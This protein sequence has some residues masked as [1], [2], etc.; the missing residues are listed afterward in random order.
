MPR[1]AAGRLVDHPS[2]AGPRGPPRPL[3]GITGSAALKLHI[4]TD[5]AS[6]LI[7]G[8]AL[9]A[10]N[11]AD[12]EAAAPLIG[13]VQA[14]EGIEVATVLADMAYSDGDT[15]V[16]VE[17]TGAALVA[18]VPPV[19][20]KG[21]FA[22]TDFVIDTVTGVVTCPAGVAT[23][24]ARPAKDHKGRAALRFVFAAGAC[25][26]CALRA[27]CTT[28]A[29]SRSIVVGIHEDR[30]AAARAAQEDPAIKALLRRRAKVERKIAHLQHLGMGKARYRGRV[31]TMLQALLAAAVANFNR[32]DVLGVFDQV[33]ATVCGA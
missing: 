23:T 5:E 4:V 16:A 28:S 19:T 10:G 1:R 24:D 20:N 31:K 11:A 15:R 9:G 8:V 22:K 18:K 12:G 27:M 2:Q 29:E 7:L 32:L 26:G 3:R 14:T 17:A 13:A 21:L 25:A 33:P 30:I 6:E